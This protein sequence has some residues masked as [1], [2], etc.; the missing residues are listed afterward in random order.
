ALT[1]RDIGAGSLTVGFIGDGFDF[2]RPITLGVGGDSG[3]T[4]LAFWNP[5]A[6]TNTFS[7]IISGTGSLR[8][9]HATAGGATVLGGANTYSGGTSLN[10]GSIGFGSST[11]PASGAI[12]SGPIGT[13]NLAI[14]TGANGVFA[15]GGAREVRNTITV[16]TSFAI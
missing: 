11:T 3:A 12:I 9:T 6:T 1:I 15:S 5:S 16:N 13:G 10:S 8:R 2:S 4:E 7:G 14:N